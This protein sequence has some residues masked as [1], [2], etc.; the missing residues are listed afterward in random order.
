M[1]AFLAEDFM[2]DSMKLNLGCGR[3]HLPGFVNSDLLG[4][5]IRA[6]A[7]ML[8]FKDACFDFVLAVHVL[9]HVSD[10]VK[11]M[12]EMHR[13]LRPGGLFEARV[14]TGFQTLYNPFHLR[15]FNLQTLDA[16]CRKGGY[17]L[18]YRAWFERVSA[19]VPSFVLPFAY[20]IE[21]YIPFLLRWLERLGLRYWKWGKP[22][23]RVP[24]TR[25]AELK[26]VLRKLPEVAA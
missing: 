13:V 6:T 4:G 12:E 25:R 26:I 3:I 8:P 18:Q 11:T 19:T 21:K 10:L 15:T 20:H 16:F 22:K 23:W 17:S 7:D 9:E 24:L 2:G 14:P 1:G 5:E